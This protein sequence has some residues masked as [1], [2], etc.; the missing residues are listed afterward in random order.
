M[1]ACVL[2]SVFGFYF[3][4]FG[5]EEMLMKSTNLL[6]AFEKRHRFLLSEFD[7][8]YKTPTTNPQHFLLKVAGFNCSKKRSLFVKKSFHFG[9]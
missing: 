3:A 5:H 1:C 7:C 2:I 8:T 4:M 6:L 9:V